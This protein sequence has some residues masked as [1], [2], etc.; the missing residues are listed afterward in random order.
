LALLGWTWAAIALLILAAVLWARLIGPVLV[1][2]RTP[3]TGASLV[4]TVATQS[5]AVLGAAVAPRVHDTWL[6]VAALVP[7]ALGLCSYVMVIWRFDLGQLT[8]G[9]G[10]QWIAGGALAISTLAAGNLTSAARVLAVLGRGAALQDAAVV[11]WAASMAWLP[12]LVVG[13]AVRPRLR[14]HLARWSTVFP[15]GMYAACSFVVASVAHAGGIAS[16]ARVWTW[17][18]L[19]VWAVVFAGMLLRTS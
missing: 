10:D 12:V 13:E 6:L 18:A 14:Y 4:V 5:L 17:I 15:F 8:A 7:F 16:F 9:R 11:L 1:H 2:W 19:A 3:T